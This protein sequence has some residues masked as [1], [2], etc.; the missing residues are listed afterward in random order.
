MARYNVTD[1]KLLIK[2]NEKIKTHHTY[3][4]DKIK[5]YQR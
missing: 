5:S 4:I 1:V 2:K 3:L